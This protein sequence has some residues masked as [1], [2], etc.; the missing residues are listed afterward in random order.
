MKIFSAAQIKNWDAFT[1]KNEP[2]SSIDLMERAA[3]ACCKW[4]I[5]KNFGVFHFRIFCGKGNNG[6]D[7]LAIARMLIEHQCVVTV[8]ILETGNMGTG[9]FQ[10]NLERLHLVSTDIHFIQTAD[11]FPHLHESDMVI[12]A[13][14]G[15]GLNKPLEGISK[16]LVKHIN[17]SGCTIVSIDL[18]SGL[19]ADQPIGPCGQDAVHQSSKDNAVV[20]ATHTLSFQNYKLAFLLNENE[21]VCG[22]VHLLHIG[23][24]PDFEE[25]EEP[26]YEWIDEAMVKS[27]YKPRRKFAHKGHYG[28]A[29]LLCGSKGMMGAAV[30]SSM[31]CLRSGAGKLTTIIPE[32]GYDILQTTVPE[33]MCIT[34]GDDHLASA[35]GIEKYTAVGI[36]PG[37][38][39]HASHNKLI[40]NLFEKV[41]SPL[42]IDADALNVMAENKELLLTIPQLSILTPHPK[43]FER[44]FGKTENEFGRLQLAKEKSIEHQ[45]YIVLK[46]HYS[47][48]S[49]PEGKGYF[50]ST[51][52]AGM[53]TA[54]SGDVL[55]GM[56][57]GLLAQ[58]Y[59]P[60]DSVILGV[61]LHGLAGD[62]AAGKFTQEAMIA[63][64]II[65]CMGSAFKTLVH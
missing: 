12:D 4:L 2:I 6:G 58:G 48:I 59:K 8:Y 52:N 31:A 23:L 28:H 56:I 7:G 33:A 11:F 36:G 10:T 3:T 9:D 54:G 16:E 45:I 22:E 37:I 40:A 20:K 44:L 38:G 34:A 25:N 64:D 55:T 14:F 61:Y 13:L 50:N 15:T 18:P 1:I 62:V 21:D 65:G 5:G 63:G 35:P 51:G 42:V 46:G 30:L 53:A 27:L 24:H 43:E 57:T 39:R 26:V 29:A 32:Y 47:F 49:T 41:T 19:F 60:S 17:Q